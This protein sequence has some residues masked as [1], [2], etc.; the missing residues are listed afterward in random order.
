MS[1]ALDASASAAAGINKVQFTLTGGSYSHT[2]IGTATST[3]YGYYLAWNTTGIP[4]GTYTLESLVTDD[5][6]NTASSAPI[7]IT[8]DNTAPVTK[9]LVPSTGADLSG[10]AVL[11]ADGSA[12]YGVGITK[13][14]FTLSGGSYNKTVIGTAV[15]SYAGYIALWNTTTVPGGT[16]TLQSLATDGAGNSSYSP[17]IT[18]TVDNTPPATA[19]LVPATGAT[20]KGTSATLDAS[21]SASYGVADLQGPVRHQRWVLHQVRP[22]HGNLDRVRVLPRLEH[23]RRLRRDLHAAEPGHRRRRQHH[24]QHGDHHQGQQLTAH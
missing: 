19:I 14:Q 1:A 4:G 16:Y 9:V 18:V 15:A 20:L 11:D 23:D 17:G 2:V 22:R 3:P 10:S 24:L 5:L 7:T 21:A 6:A 8:V 13:V 12:S